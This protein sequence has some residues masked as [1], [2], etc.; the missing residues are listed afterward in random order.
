MV[1]YPTNTRE[2]FELLKELAARLSAPATREAARAELRSL[3]EEARGR[4]EG[5]PL[6]LSEVDFVFGSSREHLELLLLPSIFAPEDWAFTF[7]EG[8]LKVPLDE[9]AGKSLVE[10][11]TGSGWIC[12]ALARCTRLGRIAGVD[13]NPHSAALAVCN[14]WLNGDEAL[15]SR[16]DFRQSDLLD[17]LPRNGSWDFV[18]GC[19]PQV[20]RSDVALRAEDDQALHD[21]SNYCAIQNVYEDHFGLGLI[22]RLLDAVPEYLSA[23]G[24]VLLNLAGRPGRHIIERM[25]SRRGF[26][27][28]VLFARR[29]RQASDTDIRPLAALEASTGQTFEFFMEAH[30]PEPLCAETAAGWLSSGQPVWHEVAVWRAQMRLL[31]ETRGLRSALERL[32]A[33]G[34]LRELDLSTTSSEQ[35]DFVAFLARQLAEAPVLPYPHEAG[36]LS[37]RESVAR[38]LERFFGLRLLPEQLFVGPD[39]EQ[40]VYSLLLSCCDAGDGVLVSRAVHATYRGALEKAGVRVTLTNDSLKDIRRLLSV[41]DVKVALLAVAPDERENVGALR[42]ILDE[43]RK[44]GILVVLDESAHFTIT[45]AVETRTLFEFLAQEPTHENLVVLYGLVKNAVYPDFELTL[46]LP[47]TPQLFADL[48]VAAESSYSRIGTLPQWYYQR[49][50]DELLTFRLAFGAE[51]PLPAPGATKGRNPRSERIERVGAFP[52]FAPKVFRR[53]DPRLVRLDYGEN[54]AGIPRTLTEGLVASCCASL[55]E[56]ATPE[57]AEAIA[58]FLLETRGVRYSPDEVVVGQGVWPL[59]H[60]LGCALRRKLGRTPRF[61]VAAPCYGMLV[62]TLVLAGCEVEA[63]PLSRILERR[64]GQAPDAVV[65]S[66]PANPEGRYLSQEELVALATY[67]VEERTLLVSDEIFGLL[68]LSNPAVERVPSVV[69]LEHTAPGVGARSL[70]LGGLSKEFAAGGLRIGWLAGKDAGLLQALREVRLGWPHRVAAEAATWLYAAFGRTGGRLQHPERHRALREY[71]TALRR[72]L[73]EK[74]AL[75]AG[76]FPAEARGGDEGE[77]G[78]LF[79]APKVSALHRKLGVEDTKAF[80]RLVYERTGV[81]LNDGTWC[82]DPERVRAVF[83]IPAAKLREAVG[84]LRELFSS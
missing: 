44:R 71:L 46:L 55:S 69:C 40:T 80:V 21:L 60:D 35:L 8:L 74:R 32:G 26:R 61:L 77:A 1:P 5:A 4:P 39:R 36:D 72:E 27:T 23:S 62:P 59:L 9:Y 16:L 66:Q 75:C 68:N 49:L 25:F 18:V 52:A 63:L 56:G 30:A 11:G 73:A 58:A 81:V 82:G 7:L 78:G 28:D 6:R 70:V 17:A 31:R 41:F 38:F 12:I 57:L 37:F 10:V 54:E 22:A 50:F 67:T 65:V 15:V 48:E 3:A 45:S 14:A 76:A 84:R 2:A 43:A 33:T 53:T 13:I 47:L 64:G 79:L 24:A 42:E 83:S 51:S 34:L 29:V 19:I 20:L